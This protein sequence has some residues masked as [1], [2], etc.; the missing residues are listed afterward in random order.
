MNSP[1][2]GSKRPV[3][4]ATNQHHQAMREALDEFQNYH[5]AFGAIIDLLSVSPADPD[6]LGHMSRVRFAQLVNM[7]HHLHEEGGE[8]AEGYLADGFAALSGLITPGGGAVYRD[9]LAAILHIVRERE[10]AALGRLESALAGERKEFDALHEEV[11]Q[12]RVVDALHE[13]LAISRAAS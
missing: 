7:L 5:Q 9:Y 11:R 6:S 13:K 4:S 12:Q 10:D 8:L 3:A 2:V 1:F